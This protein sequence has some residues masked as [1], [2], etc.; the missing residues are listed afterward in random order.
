VQCRAV[1]VPRREHARFCTA[2]CRVAWNREQAGDSPAEV[3]AL[4][5]SIAAMSDTAGRL[6]EAGSWDRRQ[7]LA[8][9]AEA[10][11]RVTIVDATLVRYHP[12]AYDGVLAGLVPGERRLIEGTLAGLRFVRNRIG[13][14]G[15]IAEFVDPAALGRGAGDGSVARWAWKPVPEP[16]LA[17]PPRA[18]AWEMTRYGGYRAAL[19]G[20]A[21]G[22]VFGRAVAFLQRAAADAAV[23]TDTGAPA[24]R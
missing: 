2:G 15:D 16:A 14:D 9:I 13:R 19:A 22:G 20:R 17:L 4:R 24:A 18:R 23:G 12:E 1:F 5:W 3:S 11:W 10:V 7:A 6:D 8:V 21:V